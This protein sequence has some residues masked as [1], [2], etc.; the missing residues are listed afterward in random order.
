M[1]PKFA[2]HIHLCKSIALNLNCSNENW[3]TENLFK[4]ERYLLITCMCTF[5]F[6]PFI[7]ADLASPS[8]LLTRL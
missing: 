5:F 3:L 4:D 8:M 2:Y 7:E 6:Y 1:I